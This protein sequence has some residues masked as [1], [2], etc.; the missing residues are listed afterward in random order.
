MARS[1]LGFYGV[2]RLGELYYSPLD[3]MLVHPK[4]A[5]I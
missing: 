2:R 4:V 5:P 1:E 3:E